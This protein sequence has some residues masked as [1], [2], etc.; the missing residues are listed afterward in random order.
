MVFLCQPRIDLSR[1]VSCVQTKLAP[2]SLLG[3]ERMGVPVT[4]GAYRDRRIA[5]R[6]ASIRWSS[7]K[8]RARKACC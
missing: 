4:I 1:E 2:L 5:S 3:A 8:R 7:T 6:T